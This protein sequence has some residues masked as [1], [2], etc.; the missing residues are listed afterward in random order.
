MTPARVI[1]IILS[2]LTLAVAG[3]SSCLTKQAQEAAK[4]ARSESEALRARVEALEV[5]N[6]EI[7]EIMARA[8]EA[9]TRANLAVTE[10]A[11]GHVERIENIETVDPD[12][13]MCPL[14]DELRDMFRDGQD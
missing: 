10:A 7:R 13:L 2:V 3:V 6:R 4:S 11:A 9:I 1:I 14:P 12:W 8:N 5:E